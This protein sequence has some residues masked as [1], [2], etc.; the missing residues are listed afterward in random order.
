MVGVRALASMATLSSRASQPSPSKTRSAGAA[1]AF[2][3]DARV[4]P[5]SPAASTAQTSPAAR[6]ISSTVIER[7]GAAEDF[8]ATGF[9]ALESSPASLNREFA[10]FLE[11]LAAAFETLLAAGLVFLSV[12]GCFLATILYPFNFAGKPAPVFP[13]PLDIPLPHGSSIREER[14]LT[15]AWTPP[16]LRRPTIF[17]GAGSRC[18]R[19]AL[20]ERFERTRPRWCKK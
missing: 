3:N 7:A 4:W 2:F 9:V 8:F 17:A 12:D 14:L 11:V 6:P 20:F 13:T 16:M 1:T 10:P 5:S 19:W 18:V 15:Q